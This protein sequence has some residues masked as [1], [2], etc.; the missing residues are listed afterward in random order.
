MSANNREYKPPYFLFNT[1]LETIY[2]ALFRSVIFDGSN[3]IEIKTDDG[4]FLEIDRY[5]SDAKKT[6]II[7]HGLEGNSR[8]VYVLGM[9]KVFKEKNWDV[10]AWNY[11]GCGQRMNDKKIFY[12]SGATYDLQ[13]VIDYFSSDYD[14]ILLLGFSLGG[15][16]ILK[17]L[18]DQSRKL[19]DNIIG[20]LAISAPIDLEGSSLRMKEAYN[21]PY[22]KRFL[23]NLKKKVRAKEKIMPG[24]FDLNRLPK[25]K[26]LYD[27]D[28]CFTAPIHGFKNAHDYY[29]KCS[30]MYSLDKIKCPTLIINAQNDTFLGEKCF[31]ESLFS[32]NKNLSFENPKRGGHVGFSLFNPD[33]MYWSE[34]RAID[35]AEKLTEV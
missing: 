9:S 32:S 2:P 33:K 31:D 5:N 16:L 6:V 13:T 18:G 24:T 23:V 10:V 1:H 4:D 12:H 26:S 7:C 28:D 11:R 30:A 22:E 17:Y 25:I 15:N 35:F 27:F 34:S 29:F 21:Y 14:K 20:G 8:K 19:A 3:Q